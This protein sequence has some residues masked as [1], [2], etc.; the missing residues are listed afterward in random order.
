LGPVGGLIDLEAES[1]DDPARNLPDDPAVVDDE[2]GFGGQ[3]PDSEKQS[4]N[5]RVCARPIITSAG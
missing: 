1:L 5:A 4:R 2:T 3:Y